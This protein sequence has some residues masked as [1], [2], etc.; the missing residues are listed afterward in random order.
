MKR[1]AF[2]PT[3]AAWILS[4]ACLAPRAAAAQQASGPRADAPV[5]ALAD[6]PADQFADPL[7]K[8]LAEVRTS[9][10]TFPAADSL[11]PQI[12]PTVETLLA[13]TESAAAKNRP[14]LALL[15]F[16]YAFED[17]AA[18]RFVLAHADARD[19]LARLEALWHARQSAF[20]ESALKELRERTDALRPALVRALAEAALG[21]ARA[22]FD[23]SL[24]YG[25]ATD[26]GTGLFY[27]GLAEA[28]AEFIECL[29]AFSAPAERR[30]L[31]ERALRGELDAL[32]RELV[33]L[34]RPPVSIDR[35]AEFITAS[36]TLKEARALADA[37]LRLGAL[38]R[39]A[40]AV[41]RFAAL[42][43]SASDAGSLAERT[44]A[45]AA[46]LAA[47]PFDASIGRVFA[48]R[49][50]ELRESGDLAAS[51]SFV[52]A[53]EAHLAALTS[54]ATPLPSVAPE[55]TVTLVRWPFT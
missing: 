28:Q 45:L 11:W 54:P 7:A 43:G 29:A 10:A 55:L 9:V 15:T 35:H 3:S 4:F 33:A 8:A 5:R 14:E 18:Q 37:G 36:G 12:A 16:A 38:L 1:A 53:L 51:A 21:K 13:R 23:A 42:K 22:N 50:D 40:Q 17:V 32:E 46:Q 39:H 6:R 34:Y 49:A 48:Q 41:Q 44:A 52:A 25:R 31:P 27:L 19:D 2:V 47:S 20:E 30:A 26:A 24:E